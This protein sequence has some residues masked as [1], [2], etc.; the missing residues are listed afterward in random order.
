M[1]QCDPVPTMMTRGPFV[2]SMTASRFGTAGRNLYGEKDS[3]RRRAGELENW[4]SHACFP[5]LTL[6]RPWL[7]HRGLAAGQGSVE[8]GAVVP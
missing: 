7:Q 8:N 5:H 4:L 3:H 6:G 2:A 1:E